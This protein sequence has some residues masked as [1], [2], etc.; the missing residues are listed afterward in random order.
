[1]L[2][3]R[4]GGGGNNGRVRLVFIVRANQCVTFKVDGSSN[5]IWRHGGDYRKR[6]GRQL[7]MGARL[8]SGEGRGKS[9]VGDYHSSL[10]LLIQFDIFSHEHL[11]L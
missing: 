7:N 11:L 9:S 2:Q 6:Q 8:G 5:S 1:M 4:R 3:R 10:Y